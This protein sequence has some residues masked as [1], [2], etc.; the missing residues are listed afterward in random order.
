MFLCYLCIDFLNYYRST[1]ECY[2]YL[3]IE[4]QLSYFILFKYYLKTS[5]KLA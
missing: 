4:N 1:F 2:D 3:T 5:S